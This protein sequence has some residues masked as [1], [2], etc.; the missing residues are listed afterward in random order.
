MKNIKKNI[1]YI[2]A[3]NWCRTSQNIWGSFSYGVYWN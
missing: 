3:V 2:Y 1:F